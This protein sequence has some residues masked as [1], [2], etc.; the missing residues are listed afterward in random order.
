MKRR[1]GVKKT[2]VTIQKRRNGSPRMI[3]S[4][5]LTTGSRNTS[6]TKGMLA[7]SRA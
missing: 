3:G 1:K 4:I 6:A 7:R 5:L 2:Q